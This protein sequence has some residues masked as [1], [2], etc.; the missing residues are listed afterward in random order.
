[1]NGLFFKFGKF[2]ERER[3]RDMTLNWN[4]NFSPLRSLH[5]NSKDIKR[6]ELYC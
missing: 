4:E 2:C 5:H 6:D 3:E 1:M